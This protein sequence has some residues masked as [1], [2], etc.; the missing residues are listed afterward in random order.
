MLLPVREK[1]FGDE[2]AVG[3]QIQ[4]SPPPPTSGSGKPAFSSVKVGQA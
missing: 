3:N 4:Q 2:P 1:P